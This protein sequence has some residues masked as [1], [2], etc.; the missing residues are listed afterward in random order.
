MNLFGSLLKD[1]SLRWGFNSK[2]T[3]KL[4]IPGYFRGFSCLFINKI[5]NLLLSVFSFSHIIVGFFVNFSSSV[6]CFRKLRVCIF[7]N[8]IFLFN[9][10]WIFFF[11]QD[12]VSLSKLYI[13][14]IMLKILF[15]KQTIKL[16]LM[17]LLL[18]LAGLFF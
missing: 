14:V 18:V 6:L 3:W 11:I 5:F 13:T 12:E 16:V 2:K 4:K 9:P 7:V 17:D 10:K 15:W 1:K 8:Y